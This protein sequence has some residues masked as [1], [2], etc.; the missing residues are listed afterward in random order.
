VRVS[1]PSLG[2]AGLSRESLASGHGSSDPF[3]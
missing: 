2:R 1:C 3:Y